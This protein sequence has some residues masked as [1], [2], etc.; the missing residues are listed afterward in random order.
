MTNFGL[1]SN[2]GLAGLTLG[3]L[4]NSE[5]GH[6]EDQQ[7]NLTLG[8]LVNLSARALLLDGRDYHPWSPASN[9]SN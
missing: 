9:L 4:V 8:F 5:T 7:S 2:F 1:I 3:L 6:S